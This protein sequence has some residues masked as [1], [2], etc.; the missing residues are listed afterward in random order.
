M[1]QPKDLDPATGEFREEPP[2]PAV[3]YDRGDMIR[4]AN[5]LY[6]AFHADPKVQEEED[7]AAV[8]AA[9][10]AADAALLE[11]ERFAK[12]QRAAALRD[13]VDAWDQ[14]REKLPPEA[15]AF[16]HQWL[17]ARADEIEGKG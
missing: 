11:A 5:R 3:G 14:D 16:V 8:A 15:A 13:A 2:A 6:A 9:F 10:L 1:S 7:S 12:A 4:R 17:R